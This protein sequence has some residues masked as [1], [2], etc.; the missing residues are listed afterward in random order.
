MQKINFSSTTQILL[1]LFSLLIPSSMAAD[2]SSPE[3]KVHIVYTERAEDQEPEAYHI[4][5]LASV[6]GSEDAAKE[7]LVY[8]YKHAASGFS[9]KLT[10]DQAAQLS[11]KGNKKAVESWK[12]NVW[13]TNCDGHA[14][15]LHESATFLFLYIKRTKSSEE[16]AKET[17]RQPSF[18]P[19][20]CYW[21]R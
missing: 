15:T 4:K 17:R 6:V 3:A 7:A 18:V 16:T 21:R 19:T 14:F 20:S 9:A 10:A 8:S 13:P 5:T 11:S 2:S 1:V 12:V